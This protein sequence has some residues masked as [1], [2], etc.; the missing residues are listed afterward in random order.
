MTV[1]FALI[2]MLLVPS[3]IFRS[4][5][6]GAIIVVVVSILVSMTLLPA[7]LGLLGDR[8]N[9]LRVPLLGR[10]LERGQRYQEGG[11]WDRITRLVMR[12]PVVS[13]VAAVAVMVALAVPYKDINTGSQGVS[14]MPP[15]SDSYRAFEILR[16]EF[17]FGT[18][19]P[20]QI[21]VHDG[22]I[23]RPEV[24]AGIQRLNERLAQDPL[25]GAPAF[26]A[27]PDKSGGLVSVAINADPMSEEAVQA[28]RDLRGEIVPAA[29]EGVDAEVLVTGITA[30]SIDYFDTTSDYTPIVFVFV[31]GLSFVLLMVVFRSLV[32]PAKAILMNLLSVGASYGA[33]VLVFQ[34]GFLN[35]LFGF[36]QV[37]VIEAWVPLWTFSILFGL[38][39]DYHVFLLSRI[40]ER[41]NRTGQNTESVAFGVRT[42]AGII[43]GAALIM[44][45]VFGGFALGDMVMFQQ[46]GFGLAVAVIL[47]ATIVRSVLV[48]A[49]MELLGAANWY[50]P[51]VLRWL[52]EIQTDG[53]E[54][55]TA[56]STR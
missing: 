44:A 32:V 39:M 43:T 40:R 2:G 6:A 55:V 11:F 1:V 29:F 30:H 7:V 15:N 36:Q 14:T 37:D 48:P 4:L 21:V 54:P 33:L 45:S 38:S 28:V 8:V 10:A 17:N 50:L 26:E 34:K 23:T 35:E 16:S 24:Q 53:P 56:P 25:F 31:L 19:A 20:T 51:P 18:V 5:G 22:D 27:S 12:Y 3:T 42:T 13:L 9:S 49:A 41:F 46:M 47:D 52:P